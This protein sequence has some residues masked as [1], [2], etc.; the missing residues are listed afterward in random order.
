MGACSDS[1]MRGQRTG[2]L[3]EAR[4]MQAQQKRHYGKKPNARSH[5]HTGQ[6]QVLEDLLGESNG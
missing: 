5:N 3:G 4:L 2:G 1:L 6:R